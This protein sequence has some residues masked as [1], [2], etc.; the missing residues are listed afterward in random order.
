MA[1]LALG[2]RT[3][4]L[5]RDMGLKL[6]YVED[7]DDLRTSCAEGFAQVGYSCEAFW[8]AE[9][10]L[11]VIAPGRYD[12]LVLDVKLPGMSGVELLQ[13]LRRRGVFTPAILV[14]AFIELERTREAINTGANYLVEK[15]FSFDQ[16]RRVVDKVAAYPISLQDCIDRG[17]AKLHLTKRDVARLVLKGLSNME[18]AAAAGISRHMLKQYVVRIFQKAQVESRTEFFS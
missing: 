12:V 18:I 6:A 8:S 10:I 2:A 15:P 3:G 11:K 17:L 13:E 5:E 4:A 14:T 16:L 7:D 9:E 1:G